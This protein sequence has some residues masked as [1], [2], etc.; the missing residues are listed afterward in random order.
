MSSDRDKRKRA[1]KAARATQQ[2]KKNREAN[3]KA[4]AAE[5]L[6]PK[7]GALPDKR[8]MDAIAESVHIA[9]TDVIDEIERS[10]GAQP[11]TP[12]AKFKGRCFYYAAAGQYIASVILG[13]DYC[14]QVGSLGVE[15]GNGMMVKIDAANG[16]VAA[17]RFHMW[18]AADD[19]GFNEYVDFTSRFFKSWA[20]ET[21]AK[22]ERD[23]LPPYLW[24][25][26]NDITEQHG[27][28][29]KYERS[30]ESET[31]RMARANE[32]IVD[33]IAEKAIAIARKRLLG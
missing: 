32:K 15:T 10:G 33:A 18:L 31:N 16:G 7:V 8:V 22:W 14:V 19:A 27:V 30:E 23:D 26:L 11:L 9:V 24:G 3:L 29:Y 4:T 20:T 21:D 13:R 12:N 6:K 28:H 5:A 1:E 17:R 2:Q 25:K